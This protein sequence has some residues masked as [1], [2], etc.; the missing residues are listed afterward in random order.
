MSNQKELIAT[1]LENNHGYLTTKAAH[2][3]GVSGVTLHR[4]TDRGELIRL[5]QGLY[6]APEIIP[7]PYFIAQY[8][9]PQ[10]IFSHETALFLH[11][12]SD[13]TPLQLMMTIPTGGYTRLLTD[14]DMLFFY[15]KPSLVDLGSLEMAT[16]FG[17]SVIAYNRERTLCDCL[18][19]IDRLDKDLVLT[20]LK[21]YAKDPE[22][23]KA[24][25][26]EYAEVFKIRDVVR[27]YLEVLS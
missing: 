26:L 24:Q 19:A 4:M 15:S 9:C 12:L 7:D 3:Q 18:R 6:V 5:A 25:L 17:L 2:E 22:C 23:N 27:R 1:L 16:P 14:S 10:G 20:A 11:D 21:R 13:R 8:R